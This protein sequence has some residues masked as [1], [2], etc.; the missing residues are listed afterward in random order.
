LSL[1]KTSSTQLTRH[2]R[3]R[4]GLRRGDHVFECRGALSC[5]DR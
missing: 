1:P 2:A 3:I 5:P 4:G